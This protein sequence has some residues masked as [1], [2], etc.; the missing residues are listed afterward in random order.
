MAASDGQPAVLMDGVTLERQPVRLHPMK[1]GIVVARPDGGSERLRFETLELVSDLPDRTILGRADLPDWRLSVAPPLPIRQRR[2]LRRSGQPSP[3]RRLARATIILLMV[4]TGALLWLRGGMLLERAAPHVPLSVTVPLGEAIVEQVAGGRF[5]A[6]PEAE[7]ALARLLAR[8]QPEGGHAEPV[9]VRIADL[10]VAN[11][12]AAPGGQVL[13][14]RGLIEAASGPDEV[15]GVLAHEL[16]HVEHRHATELLL[17]NAG[18]AILLSSL[19]SNLANFA[20]TLLQTAMS[21]EKER[22]ADAYALAI[23]A[24][25]GISPA[26]LVAFFTRATTESADASPLVRRLGNWVSTHP[27]APER[28]ATFRA[29][30][31][32]ARGTTPALS[33]SDWQALRS[34]CGPPLQDPPAGS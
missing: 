11:A 10:G 32:R 27:P 34:A 20:D 12:L 5:C 2:R 25:A 7:A 31:A 24:R 3:S 30:A 1:G 17:R 26:G 22:E 9:V 21:R 16:G 18:M 19:N 33:A 4:G 14:T 23:L 29:A 13:L 28:L 15:A 6:T 8:L